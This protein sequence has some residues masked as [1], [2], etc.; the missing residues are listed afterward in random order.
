MRIYNHI[1]SIFN[2]VLGPVM[3]GPSSSHSAAALRI[4][5]ICRDLMDGVPG[6]VEVRYDAADALAT[7]HESQGSD[8]GI[9]GG[10]LGF[11]AD[12]P[13]L[14][15]PDKH[16]LSAGI[17]VQ[18][19]VCDTGFNLPNLYLLDLENVDQKL[20]VVAISTGGGMIEVL[21]INGKEFSIRGDQLLDLQLAAKS[22]IAESA[23]ITRR[24]Y[25]VLPVGPPGEQP[26]PFK[27]CSGMMEYNQDKKLPAW[28]LAVAYES[29]RS[30]ISAEVV[31]NMMRNLYRIMREGID[32]GLR[33]TEYSDRI[34][35]PQSLA[36]QKS[37]DAGKLAGG[38]ALHN[39]TLY[40]SALMEV[41]S[42]MGTIVAAPTAG[43]CGTFPGALIG[44]ADSLDLGEEQIVKGLLA[45]SL[46]GLFIATSSTFSAEIGGCQAE[47]GAGAGMA[48]AGIAWL[49]GGSIEQAMGATSLALQNSLGMICDPI[50]ARVEAPCLGKNISSASNALVCANMA[51]AG[52]Q[53]LIPL[54][55]VIATMD[56]VGK[57]LPHELRCT[58]LGG[59]S[60]TP[61]AKKLEKGMK[62]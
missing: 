28:E 22:G 17:E 25:P 31:M 15:D 42:S 36:Y 6:K 32:A 48:A 55:E 53:H 21:R 43:S 2:D 46:V 11:E 14:E 9:K 58:A 60:I 62:P 5:R 16:L 37:L 49:L 52:Y 13:R 3:R 54:D 40:V 30:G 12:D 27:S 44:V 59:L 19:V 38:E 33:G 41:K 50:A 23:R 56:R 26:L 47:C 29:I 61:S 18:F 10:L 8:M 39:I 51:M 24:I 34:L 7:T 4:G 20:E 1:P 35:G 45:G 57:S